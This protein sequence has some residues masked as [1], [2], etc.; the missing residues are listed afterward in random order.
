LLHLYY[1]KQHY[2]DSL[3]H[4]IQLPIH[5]KLLEL[6]RLYFI[7]GG[8]SES[9]K[10]YAETKKIISK[11]PIKESIVKILEFDFLK[12]GTRSQKIHELLIIKLR[13]HY[14]AHN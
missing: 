4:K 2:H 12:Y 13:K 6:T 9:V 3:F 10:V 8:M 1:I 14:S 11:D 5:N 7:I